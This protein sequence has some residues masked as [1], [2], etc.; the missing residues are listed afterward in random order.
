[1]SGSASR[2]AVCLWRGRPGYQ[3]RVP[4]VSSSGCTHPHLPTIMAEKLTEVHAGV[5]SGRAYYDGKFSVLSVP[6][7]NTI[8]NS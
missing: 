4:V 5:T 7:S 6:T 3:V 2:R 1:M 8:W